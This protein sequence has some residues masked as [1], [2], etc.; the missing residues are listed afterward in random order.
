MKDL[1][2][3]AEVAKEFGVPMAALRIRTRNHYLRPVG[4]RKTMTYRKD[5]SKHG[6]ANIGLY[7]A[8]K[9]RELA[10]LCK[11][12]KWSQIADKTRTKCPRCGRY[13]YMS[14]ARGG[15]CLDCYCKEYNETRPIKRDHLRAIWDEKTTEVTK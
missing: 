3:I 2:S 13:D 15:L 7:D 9:L 10:R 14:K 4:T 8:D 11:E 12:G 6:A 1:A 5:G